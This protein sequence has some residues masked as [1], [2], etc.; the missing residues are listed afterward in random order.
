MNSPHL[1]RTGIAGVGRCKRIVK[2]L[3][4]VAQ[5]AKSNGK[6]LIEDVRFRDR[7]AQVEIDLRALEITLLRVLDAEREQRQRDEGYETGHVRSGREKRANANRR[8]RTSLET[9]RPRRV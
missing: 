4:N 5:Q 2:R 7:L 1:E 6:P 8:A 9:R 3:Q